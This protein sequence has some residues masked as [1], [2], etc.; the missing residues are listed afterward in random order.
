MMAKTR[1]GI[2][3]SSRVSQ[4]PRATH[5]E[6]QVTRRGDKNTVRGQEGLLRTEW[7]EAAKKRPDRKGECIDASDTVY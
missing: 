3:S 7:E 6:R 5:L 1:P 4:M 2:H